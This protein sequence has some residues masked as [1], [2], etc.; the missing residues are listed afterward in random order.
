VTYQ[1][2]DGS[3]APTYRVSRAGTYW[4]ELSNGVCRAR[5]SI[6]VSYDAPRTV[7][8][9]ADTTLCLGSLLRLTFPYP[10]LDFR[11]SNGSAAP[12]LL[13]DREGT[14]WVSY[15][16][17][18]T[19]CRQSDSLRVSFAECLDELRIPNVFTPNG[20]GYNETF[21]VTGAPGTTWRLVLHNRWGKRV[22][23]YETYRNDW[24]AEGLESGLYYYELTSRVS[25]RRFKGWVH[26]LR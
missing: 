2:Q 19:N 5:D 15:Q 11:W 13:I 24:Q 8:L 10:D 7:E 20:D 18:G 22:A 3:T 16:T 6:R 1:W 4:V 9:G 21:Q 25:G 17:P 12:E 23:G 14:Y 26:V